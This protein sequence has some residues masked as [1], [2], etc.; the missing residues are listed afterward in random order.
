MATGARN[1]RSSIAGPMTTACP[2]QHEDFIPQNQPG[3]ADKPDAREAHAMSVNTDLPGRHR[4]HHRLVAGRAA[5]LIWCSSKTGLEVD[6]DHVPAPAAATATERGGQNRPASSR[7]RRRRY[8]PLLISAYFMRMALDRLVVDADAEAAT[9]EY[10]GAACREQRR[11]AMRAEGIG[12]RHR[13]E[14]CRTA[15]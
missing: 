4:R 14:A 8:S 1:S 15:L 2:A 7:R 5:A 12:E 3:T 9:A 6:H 11:A 10:G 13:D